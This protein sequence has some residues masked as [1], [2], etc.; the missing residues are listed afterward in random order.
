MDDQQQIP[1]KEMVLLKGK[2]ESAASL[3]ILTECYVASISR[4]SLME[5]ASP[6]LPLLVAWDLCSTR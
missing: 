1:K 5:V 6:N 4:S 2:R 3:E